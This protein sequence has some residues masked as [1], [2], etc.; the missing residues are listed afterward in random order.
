MQYL[1]PAHEAVFGNGVLYWEFFYGG[2]SWL[3]PGLTAA[4]LFLLKTVGLG[5]AGGVYPGD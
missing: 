5:A 3:M 4:V 2:R 1:E